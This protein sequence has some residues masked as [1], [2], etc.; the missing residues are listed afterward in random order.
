MNGQSKYDPYTHW[1][2]TP[3]LKEAKL[4]RNGDIST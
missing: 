1:N 3:P 4:A 2:I